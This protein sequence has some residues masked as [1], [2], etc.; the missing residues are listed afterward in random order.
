MM[1]RQER[2]NKYKAL[3]TCCG[4]EGFK[5]AARKLALADLYFLLTRILKR[6]DCRRDWHYARCNEVQ[7]APND[8]L[9]L[10]AREHYKSTIITFALTI[11][12]ILRDP[13]ITVGLFSHT[14]PIAK[15]FL[16]Q[17]KREF[18][19]NE[20]LKLLFP[21]V[22]YKSPKSE[23]P[24]WSEDDG[25]VVKRQGNPKEATIEAWG[26]VDGQPTSKH[27]KL[28]VFDDVVTK[29]SVNTP[30]Q[31]KKVT[32]AWELS[33]NLGA[34]GGNT[35]YIGT[36]YHFND[37]YKTMMTRGIVTPRIYPATADGTVSGE[38][39]F[40]SREALAKKRRAMGP[41][42]FGCQMLQD[43]KAD[44]VQGFKEDWLK[45]WKGGNTNGLNLYLLCDPA[46]AK[47]RDSD[48]TCMMVLGL[49]SDEN[50]YVVDMVRDRLNLPE[51]ARTLLR[52]HR[53]WRPLA[54]GYEQYG[55]DA[56]IEH[57]Q[58]KMERENY[59][60]TITPVGGSMSKEDRI[61]RLIPYFE[62]GRL[63]LLPE[64]KRR[65]YEGVFED[66]TQVFVNDEYLSFPVSAHD[67]MLDCAARLLDLNFE[68]PMRESVEASDTADMEYDMYA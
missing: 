64:C 13:E 42:T 67:D 20:L 6:K 33:L 43:P 5:T 14:R 41:Y 22:L 31:I 46:S 26:V 47:K 11:Q 9:D 58:D 12:D 10:W 21:D 44:E 35:R 66:L 49:G 18:E 7:A 54:T 61:R 37:T 36:R 52:L 30:D 57:I 19:N 3:F 17:I 25:I 60:F 38:P 29:E 53:R 1:T 32:D 45:Y 39:V 16:R 48:Y 68:F 24:K 23:S 28:L 55:K 40:L 34:D 65:N 4:T 15:G 62:S 2:E 59:R 56:D 50:V 8:R 27:F 63:Y 51:R